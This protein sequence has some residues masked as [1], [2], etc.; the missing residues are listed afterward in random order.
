[1]TTDVAHGA[2]G[3]FIPFIMMEWTMVPG[4]PEYADCVDWLLD[5]GYK[6]HHWQSWKEYTKDQVLALTPRW[7][8]TNKVHDL[9]WLHY[10]ADRAQLKIGI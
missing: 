9:I 4:M 1:M 6:P 5:G 8:P 3:H 10:K 7:N 2:S